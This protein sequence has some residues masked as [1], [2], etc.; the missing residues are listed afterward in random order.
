MPAM[1]LS[2]F[3][4]LNCSIVIITL[5]VRQC[6]YSCFT[7]EETEVQRARVT[8]PKIIHLISGGAGI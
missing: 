3:Y 8:Q 6:H 2:A 1:I 4:V 7:D 5:K